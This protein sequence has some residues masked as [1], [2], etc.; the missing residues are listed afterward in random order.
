MRRPQ[1][2]IMY[3]S[4]SSPSCDD[5]HAAFN[6][7]AQAQSLRSTELSALFP[8]FC[9]LIRLPHPAEY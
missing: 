6:C 4:D 2:Y 1:I 8:F 5:S 3:N 9:F 7:H